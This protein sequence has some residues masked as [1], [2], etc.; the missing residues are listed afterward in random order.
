MVV[1]VSKTERDALR[2][3][4]SNSNFDVLL[5]RYRTGNVKL[6][7][8]ASAVPSDPKSSVLDDLNADDVLD[9][10]SLII[11]EMI[12]GEVYTL[13]DVQ[14]I[15]ELWYNEAIKNTAEQDIKFEDRL[16]L[17]LYSLICGDGNWLSSLLEN[18]CVETP[19]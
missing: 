18:D 9:Q 14:C 3:P 1:N 12:R 4:T 11:S 17:K 5:K 16:I 10:Q 6:A 19:N 13:R 8:L 7:L 2:G 15:L